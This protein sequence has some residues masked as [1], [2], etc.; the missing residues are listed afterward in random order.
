[1][2]SSSNG[3]STSVSDCA[4]CKEMKVNTY[5]LI[6]ELMLSCRFGLG[7]CHQPDIKLG[8]F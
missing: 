2:Q 7:V 6:P 4:K 8:G 5:A 3:L 1:M